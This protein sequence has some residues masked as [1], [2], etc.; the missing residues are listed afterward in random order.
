MSCFWLWTLA[1]K[2][3]ERERKNELLVMENNILNIAI[4]SNLSH[5][6]VPVLIGVVLMIGLGLFLHN[7]FT[8][9]KKGWGW[10]ALLMLLGIMAFMLKIAI[11]IYRE[12]AVG[13]SGSDWDG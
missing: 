6:L 7:V 3:Q 8:S 12:M 10:A 13:A 5:I 9:G 11:G 2:F 4:L 1:E